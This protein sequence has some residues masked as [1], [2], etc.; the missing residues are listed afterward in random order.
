MRVLL[1][2][3][4]G[5]VGAD[6][7][8]ALR[9]QGH[10]VIG[11]S[12]RGRPGIVACD[13]TDARAALDAVHS[14]NPDAVVHLASASSVANSYEQPAEAFAANLNATVNLAEACRRAVPGLRQFVFASS[15]E[16][17]GAGDS[18]KREDSA[19]RPSSP[20]AV[21]KL[22]AERYVEYIHDAYGIP[23]SIVRPFNT[24][25]RRHEAQYVV[26]RTL[27]QM[28]TRDVVDLGD[29][30][31]VRDLMYVE[32]HVRGYLAC[33]ANPTH[34]KRAFNLCTGRGT[35]IRE[36]AELAAKITGFQGE[37]RW[38]AAPPRPLAVA[39]IVGD[40]SAAER[41]LGWRAKTT[42]E[43]GLMRT[44]AAWRVRLDVEGRPR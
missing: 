37:I 9:E 20:Y 18:T 2:G 13:L 33:L 41:S 24:Y 25:G 30:N 17:Y 38:N 8:E 3:A 16:T 19:Q 29:P 26:E 28:L 6:L 42:L 27:V 12:R 15:S 34:G 1:T 7:M 40:P 39:R 14:A 44:A 43:D 4:S 11:L 23:V 32:D 5:F 31:P 36:L 10:D 21:S 22:A 35:S